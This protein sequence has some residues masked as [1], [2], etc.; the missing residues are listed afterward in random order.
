[1]LEDIKVNSDC[2]PTYF[3]LISQYCE[4][5]LRLKYITFAEKITEMEFGIHLSRWL[6][7]TRFHF[8]IIYG[9]GFLRDFADYASYVC[10]GIKNFLLNLSQPAFEFFAPKFFLNVC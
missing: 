1:M 2:K 7:R 5:R 10:T 8:E 6:E 3:R 4:V 9:K